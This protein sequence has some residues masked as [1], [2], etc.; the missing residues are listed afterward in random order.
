LTDDIQNTSLCDAFMGRDHDPRPGSRMVVP[1]KYLRHAAFATRRVSADGVVWTYPARPGPESLRITVPGGNLTTRDALLLGELGRRYF[2]EGKPEDGS[3][4]FSLNEAAAAMGYETSGGWQRRKA[5]ASVRRLTMATVS[6]SKH[7]VDEAGVP[8]EEHE[9]WHLIEKSGTRLGANE[10]SGRV[11]LSEDTVM[12]LRYGLLAYLHAPVCKALVNEDEIAA[13][14]W[15]FLESEALGKPFS[16]RLLRPA[17]AGTPTASRQAFIAEVVG[18]A[19]WQTSRRVRQRIA[20][21]VKV[22]QAIDPGRYELDLWQN[23][24]GEWL[25]TAK[26]TARRVVGTSAIPG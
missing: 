6:W 25:L 22:V 20:S 13:R 9:D 2:A 11:R 17:A 7:W 14:L 18:I 8:C 24:A 12:L 1:A 4:T 16:Y 26:R 3:V 21:A 10:G 19:E 23:A 5:A 15:M